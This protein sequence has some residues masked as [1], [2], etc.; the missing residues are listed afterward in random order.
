VVPMED[1]VQLCSAFDS[2]QSMTDISPHSDEHVEW[3]RTLDAPPTFILSCPCGEPGALIQEE[4][5]MAEQVARERWRAHAG[6]N[7]TED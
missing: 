7:Q 2:V 1:S 4:G 6:L 3:V 5:A